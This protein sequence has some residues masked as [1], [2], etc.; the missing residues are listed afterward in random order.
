MKL[1]AQQTETDST[2]DCENTRTD[3]GIGD[4]GFGGI[5]D[6]TILCELLYEAVGFPDTP[7]CGDDSGGS[8]SGG[9]GGSGSGGGGAPSGG[10]PSVGLGAPSFSLR[11]AECL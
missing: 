3:D 2:L 11:A 1:S 9:S 7:C 10:A 8:G 5:G 4:D 6:A